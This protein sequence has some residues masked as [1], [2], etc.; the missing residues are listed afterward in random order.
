ML[1]NEL[2]LWRCL[3]IGTRATVKID[4]PEFH[5]LRSVLIEPLAGENTTEVTSLFGKGATWE[6]SS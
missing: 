5:L 3:N 2:K 1:C 6:E 4:Q